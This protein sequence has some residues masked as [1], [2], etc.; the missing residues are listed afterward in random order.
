MKRLLPPILALALTAC[1]TGHDGRAADCAKINAVINTPAKDLNE[2]KIASQFRD[3]QR[4]VD[5]KRL[6]EQVG[7]IAES[8]EAQA[9]TAPG[10][11]YAPKAPD[12]PDE[13]GVEADNK[14]TRL[15]QSTG[16]WHRPK[17]D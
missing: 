6:A 5:D 13:R 12:D 2:A 17:T 11:P 3:L 16:K 7:I 8:W 15:C 1:A 10:T 9:R 14:L 4:E